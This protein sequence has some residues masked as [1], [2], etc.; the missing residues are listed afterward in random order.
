MFKNQYRLNSKPKTSN[1]KLQ[2]Q[3]F[4]KMNYLITYCDYSIN[5][6][7]RLK[8][9]QN[10]KPRFLKYAQLHNFKFV[11]I[12]ENCAAPYNL[13]FAKV[14]W[15]KQNWNNFN[16]GDII[17]YMDIDC[18]VMDATIPPVFE[19]DF[20]IVMESTGVLCMG[21]LW[22]LRVS[23][24][25]KLFIDEMCSIKR[26]EE[27]KDLQSWKTW[28]ENDVIYHVLGLNWGEKYEQMGTRNSTPFNQTELFEHIE[29]LDSKWGN[30]FNFDDVDWQ[31]NHFKLND[32]NDKNW[33]YK[34][35]K[36]YAIPERCHT[37]ENT[38]IR[39]LSAETMFIDWANNYF[40]TPLKI[41]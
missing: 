22:S 24:W 8:Y 31:Q 28:H 16:P 23:D 40:N 20:S 33:I 11:E 5:H 10:T 17:A 29:F 3:N 36:Q 6:F 4:L 34:V 21:G 32:T 38:I 2:T 13:G 15:I 37:I 26:Q 41:K 19:K 1:F 12:N 39:H 18:C 9:E 35:I 7:K 25:S 30:T 14:F 27:N